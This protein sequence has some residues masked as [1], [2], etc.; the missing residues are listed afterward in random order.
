MKNAGIT[1]STRIGGLIGRGISHS[2][3][4]LIHNT[5]A[6][7]LGLDVVY[8]P[9]DFAVPPSAEF[10]N[11]MLESNCYGFNITVPYKETVGRLF[12]EGPQSCN[13]L[14]SQNGQWKSASTDADGFFR[15]LS[16]IDTDVFDFNA[17]ICLGYG[18]A[19]KALIASLYL[20]RPDLPL[21]VLCRGE[22]EKA[23]ESLVFGKFEPPVLTA[24]IQTHP[25]A[26]VIQCTS[27]P[28]RGDNLE[29]FTLAGLEGVFVDLV[30]GTPSAM[31]DQAKAMD[32]PC[33]DGIPMLIHQALVSQQLWWGQAA[34]FS[35]M[36][37][38][39]LRQS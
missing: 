39:I 36:K 33:Q 25:N 18:G 9:F 26:L 10:F 35:D 3:S 22:H 12:P 6:R 30:Y 1:G 38:A 19:A 8:V 5:A 34:S 2:L 16:E 28:L 15:G 29:Q 17:V 11:Q 37:A 4:P 13:T 20:Q 21:F 14:A 32:L 24:L 31:L 27:A 7:L 23:L